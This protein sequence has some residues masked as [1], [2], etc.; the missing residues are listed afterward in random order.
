MFNI[1]SVSITGRAI[2]LDY[3]DIEWFALETN[4]DH[5]V[6][7]EIAPKYCILNSFVDYDGYSTHSLKNLCW[8]LST[9]VDI[10]VICIKFFLFSPFSLIPK[11][12]EF[13]VAICYLTTSKL[14]WFM[15]LTFQV[16]MPY[17]FLQHW[18]LLPSPVTSITGCCFCF[19]SV[20]SFFLELF[21]HWSP[22]AYCAPTD[23]NRPKLN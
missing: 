2:D 13:T 6:I 4:R 8:F 19:G 20:S 22:V 12:S 15:D 14:P 9:V 1:S 10:M 11:I 16:S 5:S 3:H 17:C 23:L 21:F 18:T 7:F